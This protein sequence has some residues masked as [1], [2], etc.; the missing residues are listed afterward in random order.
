MLRFLSTKPN[1]IAE[2]KELKFPV[3]S[4]VS[5]LLE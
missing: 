1:N 2:E 4:K 3:L 5:F